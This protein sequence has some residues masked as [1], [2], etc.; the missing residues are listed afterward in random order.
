ME[1]VTA[2]PV[3]EVELHMQVLAAEERLETTRLACYKLELECKLL[4]I[5][6][7]NQQLL[8]REKARLER[9]AACTLEC[10]RIEA[11]A[12]VFAANAAAVTASLPR[13]LT[14][15]SDS[16]IP[17]TISVV[18]AMFIN[19]SKQLAGL[20]LRTGSRKRALDSR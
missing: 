11:Q 7:A 1:P 18:T 3:S 9:E 5:K 15:A 4:E 14:E 19:Q 2:S 17:N 20:H 6:Y 10:A 13:A 12:R 16:S 8:C